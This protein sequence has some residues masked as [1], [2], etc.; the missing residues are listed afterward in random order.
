MLFLFLSA[1]F[2]D[3]I[4]YHLL[5]GG[6]E[7]TP[8]E[9]K[10]QRYSLPIC[11]ELVVMLPHNLGNWTCWIK[12]ISGCEEGA[13]IFCLWTLDKQNTGKRLLQVFS[14]PNRKSGLNQYKAQEFRFLSLS[15]KEKKPYGIPGEAEVLT[16]RVNAFSFWK[17]NSFV[18]LHLVYDTLFVCWYKREKTW[19]KQ[20]ISK[21][22]K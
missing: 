4:L 21:K 3:T 10:R 20:K 7:Y 14:N 11:W 19:K 15:W 12:V 8:K 16:M 22:A 2:L 1:L 5:F 9:K 17:S 6:Q 13:L 18:C